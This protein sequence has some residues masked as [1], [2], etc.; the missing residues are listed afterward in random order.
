MVSPAKEQKRIRN[1]LFQTGFNRYPK[2][3]NQL[4]IL[5]FRAFR[6]RVNCFLDFEFASMSMEDS[7]VIRCVTLFYKAG[8][9]KHEYTYKE[10]FRI[11]IRRELTLKE[12]TNDL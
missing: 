6:F 8:K 7:D 12:L 10:T 1:L 3:Q 2:I 11:S 4:L 5:I 9:T